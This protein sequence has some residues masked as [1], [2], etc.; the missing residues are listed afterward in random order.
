M[1]D[2]NCFGGD[3]NLGQRRALREFLATQPGM[4]VEPLCR[5]GA[6]SQAFVVRLPR[7]S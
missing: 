2:W 6:N 4:S 5:Y 3:D 7:N 1:D